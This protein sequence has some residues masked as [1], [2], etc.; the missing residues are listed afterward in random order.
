[1]QPCSG[2]RHQGSV[3]TYMQGTMGAATMHSVPKP[4]HR[5][6]HLQGSGKG[7][8]ILHSDINPEP[9]LSSR[10]CSPGVQ[11]RTQA[12]PRLLERDLIAFRE[13]HPTMQITILWT[14]QQQMSWTEWRSCTGH[15][16]S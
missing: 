8:C 6:W 1:M 15:D 11:G 13:K 9:K 12:T 2:L 14:S 16:A 3:Y 10:S 7:G 4:I 5:S